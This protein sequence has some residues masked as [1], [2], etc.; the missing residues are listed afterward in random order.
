MHHCLHCRA[1]LR[2][3]RLECPACRLRYEGTFH[4]PRLARLEPAQQHLIEQIVM[5]GG[6]LKEVSGDLQISYPTLRKRLDALILSLREL[7]REDEARCK[8]LLDD[9]E[10]GRM[11]PEEASRLVKEIKGGQ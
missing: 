9:V 8:A 10:A 4:L 2:V 11:T 5:A 1:E 7:Q 6:N 3:A